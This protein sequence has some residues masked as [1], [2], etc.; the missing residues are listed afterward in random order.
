MTHQGTATS[1]DTEVIVVENYRLTTTVLRNLFREIRLGVHTSSNRKVAAKLEFLDAQLLS[2][3]Y[4][5]KMYDRLKEI[6]GVAE[7]Y[8]YE[9]NWNNQYRAVL[10]M[11]QLGHS[12]DTLFELCQ[13]QFSLKTILYIA[14]ELI[15]IFEAVHRRGIVYRD[16]TPKNFLIG[17]GER[18]QKH[19]YL[20]DF[21]FS[22]F[23]LDPATGQHIV[24]RVDHTIKVGT[25][26]YMSLNVHRGHEHSRRDDMESLGY[27]FMYF[28]KQGKL[29]WSKLKGRSSE[30][31]RMIYNR[32]CD[33]T[34]EQ[35]CQ[36]Y[37]ES[38]AFFFR[39]VKCL[40]FTAEPDYQT[41]Q[42]RFVNLFKREN[43]LND[44]HYD[45][46]TRIKES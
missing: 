29:P 46:K 17:L 30:K 3:Q 45:W 19:L 21:A 43:F 6:K 12:L 38:F 42:Q 31:E 33:T 7:I 16:V 22:K 9:E 18:G 20:V 35:L 41:L 13:N 26:R 40:S 10:I 28:L 8:Y 2:L 37:P 5:K 14:I 32:K 27:V 23:Y 36:N 25:I 39:Q 34:I 44:G 24:D 1:N 11:Q 15:T 4:E